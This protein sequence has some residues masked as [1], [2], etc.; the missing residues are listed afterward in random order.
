MLFYLSPHQ[1]LQEVPK[2]ASQPK[3]WP[4]SG[5]GPYL[6]ADEARTKTSTALVLLPFVDPLARKD[7]HHFNFRGLSQHAN[8][9]LEQ[10][11]RYTFFY[12]RCHVSYLGVR[13]FQHVAAQLHVE[14]SQYDLHIIY[15]FQR[16]PSVL[17]D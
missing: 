4:N 9:L 1:R 17:L 10:P 3:S 8:V 11:E 12:T 6:L 2:A 7:Y 13:S 16:G 14:V 15:S 5:S